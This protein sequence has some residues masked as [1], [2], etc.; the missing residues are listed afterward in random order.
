MG[1]IVDQDG[2]IDEN[3]APQ[4]QYY[5]WV[6]FVFAIQAAVFY[7]PFK[8]WSALEGGLIAS[9]GTEA[10]NKVMVS[11]DADLEDECLVLEVLTDRFVKYFKCVFHRNTWY[12]LYFVLCK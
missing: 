5:Q 7:M 11:K 3:T 8:I 9:F 4:T 12:F 2:V 1:C 6:T 10:K